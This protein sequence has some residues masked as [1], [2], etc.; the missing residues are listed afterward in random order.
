V[1]DQGRAVE[2]GPHAKLL[3]AGGRYAQMWRLQQQASEEQSESTEVSAAH[4]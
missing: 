2:R 3:A 1:L 4:R